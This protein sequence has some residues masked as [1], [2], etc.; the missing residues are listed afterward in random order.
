MEATSPPKFVLSLAHGS[1]VSAIA[2]IEVL[3]RLE[4]ETG[5][6]IR[7]HFQFIGG[8]GVGGVIAALTYNGVPLTVNN[9]SC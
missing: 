5:K 3:K 9:C 2:Q 1:F 6:S 4:Y 8:C 7:E